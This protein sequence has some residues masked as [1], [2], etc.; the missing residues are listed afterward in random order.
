MKILHTSDWHLGKRPQGWAGSAY[1]DER[2][3]DFFEAASYTVEKAI[4]EKVELLIIA[5]DLFDSNWIDADILF[6]TERILSKL[7]DAGIKTLVIAG[8]HDKTYD[9][10]SWISYLSK[11]ELIINLDCINANSPNN[12]EAFP[13]IYQGIKIYGIPY[14]GAFNDDIL[15]NLAQSLE[16]SE[17]LIVSHTA[18]SNFESDLSFLPGCINSNVIDLFKEKTIY[19]AAGHFH[20]F[21]IYPKENPYFFIPGS[22]EYWD[23]LEREPKGFIVFDTNTKTY[24]FHSSK[25]RKRSIYKVNLSEI[26]E[27]LENLLVSDGEIIIFKISVDNNKLLQEQPLKEYIKS[28]GALYVEFKYEYNHNANSVDY[29]NVSKELIEKQIVSSWNNMYSSTEKNV[30]KT[31]EF[32]QLAKMKIIEESKD[33]ESIFEDFDAFLNEIIKGE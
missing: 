17:N 19:F 15:R 25:K 27:F 21:Q 16:G 8:N 11:K 28:K 12:F 2:Y 5:G 26:E 24:N 31:Y 14:Q 9:R 6:R 1:S 13:Y 3:N 29:L 4:E 22:L 33:P 18:I 7:K 32:L 30:Q 20:S 23:I 10:E